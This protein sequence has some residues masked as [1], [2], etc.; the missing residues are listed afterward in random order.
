MHADSLAPV[1]HAV[2]RAP[3]PASARRPLW[4][5]LVVTALTLAACLAADVPGATRRS[6]GVAPSKTTESG[7]TIR[8]TGPIAMTVDAS[9]RRLSPDAEEEVRSA[10]APWLTSGATLPPVTLEPRGN[11]VVRADHIDFPGHERDLAFTRTEADRTTGA[12]RAVEIVLNTRYSWSTAF[13]PPTRC[14]AYD[15]R[16]V[17]VHELGHAFGLGE[18][19]DDAAATMFLIT[20]PCDVRKRRLTEADVVAIERLYPAGAASPTASCA[21]HG[22]HAKQAGPALRCLALLLG[23]VILRRRQRVDVSESSASEA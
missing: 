23:A 1:A 7:Q 12:I 21:V 20:P 19:R 18:D 11:L 15:I 8:W 16:S 22:A 3:I 2:L 14:G 17:V 6:F 13:A 9:V 4:T 10:L 5:P